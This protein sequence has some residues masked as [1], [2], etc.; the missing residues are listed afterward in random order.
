M[1]AGAT[2]ID[3]RGKTIIPG[4][5]DAH[6]HL[7]GESDGL[8]AQTSWPL[9]ANLAFGVTTSH[10]PSNDTETVFSNSELVRS[11]AKLGPRLYSTGTIL[12]GAESPFKATIDNYDDA[13]S[14]LRRLKAS[15]A[16]SVKS[17]NQQRRDARQMILKAGRELQMNVVPEGGSLLYH[18]LTMITDG[19][20]TIEHSLPVANI[21][22]DVVE[23]WSHTKVAHTPTLIV[24]FGGLSASSSGT[25]ATTCGSTTGCSPSR[26]AMSSMRVPAGASR[27]RATT[28][29][30]MWRSPG[31]SSA[32]RMPASS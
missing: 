28:T 24:G 5:I 19:H 13:L 18:D 8:L 7:G 16:F 9:L 26:R 31:T 27:R 12:Y 6:A 29:S 15:G 11:G 2:R 4:L 22:R 3:A 23:L 10:D 32:W 1:P 20:T 30:I 17:Y 21:Y 25:S 14:H